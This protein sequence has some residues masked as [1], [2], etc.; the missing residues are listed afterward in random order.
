MNIHRHRDFET[1][2]LEMRLIKP[3]ES[4]ND[5][6][7]ESIK[8]VFQVGLFPES[9]VATEFWSKQKR[10]KIGVFKTHFFLFFFNFFM[11]KICVL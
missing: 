8:G 6:K 3:I 9:A 5:T 11:S 2:D 7:S 4:A 1:G 10:V